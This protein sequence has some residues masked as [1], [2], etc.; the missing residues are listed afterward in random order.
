MLESYFSSSPNISYISLPKLIYIARW[1]HA[2]LD[3]NNSVLFIQLDYYC[4]SQ[5]PIPQSNGTIK[6]CSI[7]SPSIA[8]LHFTATGSIKNS[9]VS[10]CHL[11]FY[12][13]TNFCQTT[14]PIESS[15]KIIEELGSN[16]K[17]SLTK[18][19]EMIVL[20]S[21]M[22]FSLYFD[23]QHLQ[24][25]WRE[26]CC[27]EHTVLGEKVVLYKGGVWIHLCALTSELWHCFCHFLLY[28]YINMF[29]CL[30]VV[31]RTSCMQDFSLKNPSWHS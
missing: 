3:Y 8:L 31:G 29:C 17:E 24:Q 1:T 10:N 11:K 27:P 4:S 12:N 18:R 25:E 26:K 9:F 2:A 15:T 21:P 22:S 20:I 19:E 13:N 23:L 16:L 6:N 28:S 30:Q 7:N 5:G 14:A